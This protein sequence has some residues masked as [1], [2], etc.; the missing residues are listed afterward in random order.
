M[1]LTPGG[2]L[3]C[4]VF[5]AGIEAM[6]RVGRHWSYHA[7]GGFWSAVATYLLEETRYLPGACAWCY[8]AIVLDAEAGGSKE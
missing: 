5:K 1:S 2:L 8:W 3:F 6:K 7:Q 4:D